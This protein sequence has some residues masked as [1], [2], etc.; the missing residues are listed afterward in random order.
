MSVSIRQRVHGEV[1]KAWKRAK[2]EE[3]SDGEDS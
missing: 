3:G 2:T 1:V